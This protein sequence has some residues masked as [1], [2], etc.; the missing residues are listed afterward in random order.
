MGC[1]A[2]APRDYTVLIHVYRLLSDDGT[3][4][5]RQMAT[6]AE[7]AGFG[8]FHTGVEIDG[9]EYSYGRVERQHDANMRVVNAHVSGVWT[10]R[11]KVLPP[12]FQGAQHK[13]TVTAGVVT[14]TPIALRSL[15]ARVAHEWRGTDYDAMRHNCNHFSA[16]LCCE[17]GV[18]PPP[19]YVNRLANAGA[20]V[21]DVAR[22]VMSS[23]LTAGASMLGGI[24]AQAERESE[25]QRQR[26]QQQQQQRV[27]VAGVPVATGT[28][29]VM[30]VPVNVNS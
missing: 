19:E 28:Q 7:S 24:L 5:V 4:L 23:M 25:R 8:V 27:P 30:G 13:E 14:M 21:A 3:S 12:S 2:S 9:V 15:I 22:S 11:P 26:Q 17:L 6:E 1:G 20:G 18:D 10:Q 16:A 29:P